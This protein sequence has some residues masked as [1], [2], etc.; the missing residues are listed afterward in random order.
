MSQDGTLPQKEIQ[1]TAR[2][3]PSPFMRQVKQLGLFCAGAGFLAASVAVSRRSVLR[4]RKVSYPHFYWSNRTP[5]NRMD[6][7]D[8]GLVAVRALGLATLNVTGFGIMLVGGIGW[9]FNLSSIQELRDRTRA[10][11][12]KPGSFSSEDE[13]KMEAEMEKILDAVYEKMGMEKPA[14]M[15]WEE[16]DKTEEAKK[17]DG[18]R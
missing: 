13:Q 2:P 10:S 16:M 18:E 7:S 8:N 6:S 9:A 17:N 4:M 15:D 11:L 12:M 3:T 5:A 14:K 1:T